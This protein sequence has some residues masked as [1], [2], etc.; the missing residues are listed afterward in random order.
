VSYAHVSLLTFLN[1][2]KLARSVSRFLLLT[3]WKILSVSPKGVPRYFHSGRLTKKGDQPEGWPPSVLS[4][5][6]GVFD[7]FLMA[8]KGY[9]A[10][11]FYQVVFC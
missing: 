9:K 6:E 2:P 8:F 4:V 3:L 1:L 11:S 7:V 5:P 10:H